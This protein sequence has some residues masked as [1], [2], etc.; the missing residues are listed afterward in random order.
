MR[1]HIGAGW[2]AHEL[3]DAARADVLLEERC[4]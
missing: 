2:L 3:K 1:A 4:A